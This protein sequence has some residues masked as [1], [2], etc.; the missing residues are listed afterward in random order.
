[1]YRKRTIALVVIAYNE[2]KLIVPTLQSVPD[3]VDRV[4]VVDDGSKDGTCERV[5]KQAASDARVELV[6]H[7]SNQGPGQAIIT[8][9]LRS[10][11]DGCDIAVVAGGDHQMPLEQMPDLLDPIVEGKVEYTKGNRFL[12]P[13]AGLEDMPWTRVLGNSLISIMTKVSSGYYKVYDVVDGFTAISKRAIDLVSWEHA[14]KGYGYPMEFLV[15]LNAYGLR[16]LDV[17]RRAIYLEGERQSQIRGVRYAL[18]VAPMLV[19][20]FFWRLTTKYLV[21]DFHP[22]FFFYMFGLIFLPLGVGFGGYLLYQQWVGIGVSGP[23]AIVCALSIIMGIQ[24]LLFAM[25]YDMQESE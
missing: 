25:L 16:V 17:P 7:G 8:G 15:R 14:W 20:R 18:Q 9:Y 22:L 3:L 6:E 23:R 2:E 12:M 21:R 19:H 4:Y 24:F 10:S 5:R 13:D 11:E 1:M